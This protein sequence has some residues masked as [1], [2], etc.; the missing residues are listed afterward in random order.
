MSTLLC[1]FGNK[2]ITYL[3]I[4]LIFANMRMLSVVLSAKYG[5]YEKMRTIRLIF[6]V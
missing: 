5:Q 6:G 3:F 2:R 4:H 1:W